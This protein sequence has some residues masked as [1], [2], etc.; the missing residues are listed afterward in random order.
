[1]GAHPKDGESCYQSEPAALGPEGGSVAADEKPAKPRPRIRILTRKAGEQNKEAAHEVVS[2]DRS[3]GRGDRS[4]LGRA[5]DGHHVSK[6]DLA[7]D[8]DN[9]TESRNIVVIDTAVDGRR[10]SESKDGE[11]NKAEE[12]PICVECG[13]TFPSLKALYGHLRCHPLRGYKGAH[14]PPETKKKKKLQIGAGSSSDQVLAAK[15]GEKGIIESDDSVVNAAIILLQMSRSTN[16]WTG[17]LQYRKKTKE[18]DE[19]NIEGDAMHAENV[20]GLQD[21]C[22]DVGAS[23]REENV[24]KKKKKK[25]KIKDLESVHEARPPTQD[26]SG[27]RCNICSKYF[28]THQALGGHTASHNKKNNSEEVDEAEDGNLGHAEELV[29]S[30]NLVPKPATTEHRCTIC[31]ATFPTGQALGGH[32]RKHWNG[33]VTTSPSPPPAPSPVPL[34]ESVQKAKNMFMDI[35]LNELPKFEG[36]EP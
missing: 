23:S 33:P 28:P 14:R 8:Q 13:K 29:D 27:Y 12:P 2:S 20:D 1:M 17:G 4:L 15:R 22:I 31:Q 16:L 36:G 26:S 18:M 9:H 7:D 34:A 5:S 32:K 25:K 24:Q 11:D 21:E 30:N 10:S 19:K 6:G 3:L 35:D